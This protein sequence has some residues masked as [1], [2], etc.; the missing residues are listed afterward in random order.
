MGLVNVAIG[1][2]GGSDPKLAALNYSIALR[3]D[4][5][6]ALRKPTGGH[7]RRGRA[8]VTTWI[9]PSVDEG[10]ERLRTAIVE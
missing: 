2:I 10:A 7:A 6:P 1:A 5:P 9:H 8:Y 3:A 4:A